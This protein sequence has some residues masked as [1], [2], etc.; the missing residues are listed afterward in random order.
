LGIYTY[1]IDVLITIS[2][3]GIIIFMRHW[4]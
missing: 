2:V 1:P 3:V 4:I